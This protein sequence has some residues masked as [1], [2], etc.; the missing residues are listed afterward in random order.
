MRRLY[1]SRH[2]R[3]FAGILG[4]IGEYLGIDPTVIRVAFIIILFLT[5]VLPFI[6]LYLVLLLIIPEQE[7]F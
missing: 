5:A 3:V 7:T 1:R 6:F 4:G 2:N